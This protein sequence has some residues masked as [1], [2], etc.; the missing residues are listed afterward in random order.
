MCGLSWKQKPQQR[1]S[2]NCSLD[3]KRRKEGLEN[4]VTEQ[5]LEILRKHE[6]NKN[7]E[8][9]EEGEGRGRGKRGKGRRGRGEG[10][11]RGEGGGG[12]GE[13]GGE[14]VKY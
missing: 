2:K 12:G 9:G 14:M 1:S 7:S 8:G 10:E 6:A 13:R 11:G 5:Q 4:K 3:M